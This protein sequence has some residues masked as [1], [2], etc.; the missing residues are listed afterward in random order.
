MFSL[1]L[2]EYHKCF[3]ICF[4]IATHI[5]YE[6]HQILEERKDNTSRAEDSYLPSILFR[7]PPKMHCP[8]DNHFYLI[9]LNDRN[10]LASLHSANLMGFFIRVSCGVETTITNVL[11]TNNAVVSLMWSQESNHVSFHPKRIFWNIKNNNN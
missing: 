9:F 10:I 7:Q 4:Y 6:T 3:I 1:G 11:W 2:G 8:S 5:L